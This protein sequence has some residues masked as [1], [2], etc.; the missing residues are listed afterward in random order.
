MA[1]RGCFSCL[2][3]LVFIVNFLFWL[4]GLGVMAVSLWLLFDQHLY[5][6]TVTEQRGDY[7]IGTYIIL[8]VGALMTLVGFLGCCGAWK[9]SPW[10]LG[11]FFV[12][13][14]II[15][16]GEVT[17]VLLIYF[18][19]ASYDDLI[20]KSVEHTVKQKYHSNS[21][22]TIA[23]FDLIQEGLN[24]CGGSGPADWSRSLYNENNQDPKE[25]GVGGGPFRPFNIPV[26]CCKDPN[27]PPCS[28]NREVQ[29]PSNI[30]EY[31]YSTGCSEKLKAFFHEHIIY[32]LAAAGGVVVLEILGMFFSMCLCCALKRIEDFKA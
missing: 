2:K 27:N 3:F 12:F 4:L 19:Q 18:Q 13:L 6:Q 24:C 20:D 32:L 22:A 17:A 15:F 21:S 28:D 16:L 8:G 11:T 25:I 31:Y 9:E 14:V 5:L 29:S 1:L 26:S 30:P 10:M 23:T 7:F